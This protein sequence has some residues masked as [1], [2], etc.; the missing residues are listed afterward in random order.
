MQDTT[1]FEQQAVAQASQLGPL[2]KEYAI[3][4]WKILASVGLILVFA[5]LVPLFS[6]V[7]S[8]QTANTTPIFV[9]FFMFGLVAG[10]GIM[11]S[12]YFTYRRLHVYVYSHGLLYLN[13]KAS[14]VVYWQQVNQVST[15]RGYLYVILSNHGGWISIPWYLGGYG[16]LRTTIQRKI[17]QEGPWS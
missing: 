13:G 7:S 8:R 14:K 15:Y 9:F 11:L 6:F 12:F 5:L 1:F 2:E 17:V 4:P 3:D 16:E 10:G